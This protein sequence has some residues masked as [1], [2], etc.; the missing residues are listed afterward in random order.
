M[1]STCPQR[2][3]FFSQGKSINFTQFVPPRPD[4]ALVRGKAGTHLR[5]G[6]HGCPGAGGTDPARPKRLL[7]AQCPL[8]GMGDHGSQPVLV[9]AGSASKSG[10]GAVCV[11]SLLTLKSTTLPRLSRLNVSQ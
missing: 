8:G 9:I 2:A 1:S 7:L 6:P 11:C 3:A 10:L 4:T 5:V